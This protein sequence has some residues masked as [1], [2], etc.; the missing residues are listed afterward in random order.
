M[1]K[2]LL[3]AAGAVLLA[4]AV[5]AFIYVNKESNPMDELFNANVEALTGSESS[6]G[7]CATRICGKCHIEETAWPFYKCNWSGNP[8]DF[9]DCNK[10]GY[11]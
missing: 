11:L 2:K 5:S 9:C 6:Q 4:S 7:G 10:L 1:K 3:L 8:E